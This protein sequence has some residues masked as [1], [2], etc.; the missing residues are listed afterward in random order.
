MV[1]VCTV[2]HSGSV[3]VLLCG[4][5]W[6]ERAN[7]PIDATIHNI[8]AAPCHSHITGLELDTHLCGNITSI[9]SSKSGSNKNVQQEM[10]R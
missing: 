6:Q 8:T 2:G 9:L 1:T 5:M 3:A 10:R 7:K 4:E